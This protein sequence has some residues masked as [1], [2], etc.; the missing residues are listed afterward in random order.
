M[1]QFPYADIAQSD[2][3]C[4]KVNFHTHAG[5][6]IPGKCGIL[7]L[8]EVTQAYCK[9]GYSALAVSNHDVYTPHE[10]EREGITLLD[11]VEYSGKPHMLQVGVQSYRDVTHQE[12]IDDTLRAGGFAVMCHPN[13]GVNGYRDAQYLAKLERYQGYVGIEIFNPVIYRLCGSGLAL[14]TWD[15]LLSQGRRVWGF[16]NDD[17]HLW[18]DMARAWNMLYAKSAQQAD[19]IEAVNAGRFYV[20]SG[21]VLQH[22]T[23]ENNTLF[24][25]ADW[26]VPSY[27]KEFQFTVTGSKGKVLFECK[28]KALSFP[29]PQ[30]EPYLRIAVT[31]EN[32]AKLFLQP[33]FL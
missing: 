11:A 33:F 30:N 23:I 27:V 5:V 6:C 7:P 8:D 2:F 16:G 1:L 9:A 13:W 22:C 21:L 4:F 29:L 25:Q 20:S 12:A 18:Q 31:G 3:Q 19:I 14:D 32:G 17:F 26:S 24:V 10:R 15:Y 28:E